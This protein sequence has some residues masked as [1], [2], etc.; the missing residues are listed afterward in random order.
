MLVYRGG[1]GNIDGDVG[2]DGFGEATRET[3]ALG[4]ARPWTI[5]FCVGLAGSGVATGA[6]SVGGS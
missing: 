3:G 4:K 2:L 1:M 5:D 6:G